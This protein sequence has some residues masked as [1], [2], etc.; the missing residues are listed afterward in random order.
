MLKKSYGKMASLLFQIIFIYILNFYA[1]H[2]TLEFG[3]PIILIFKLKNIFSFEMN[4]ENSY[5]LSQKGVIFDLRSYIAPF[6][7]WERLRILGCYCF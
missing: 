2:L 3:V 6:S 1:R 5:K 7:V 4:L